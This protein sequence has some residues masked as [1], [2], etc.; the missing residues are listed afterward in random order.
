MLLPL[1]GDASL[2]FE[3]DMKRSTLFSLFF[4]FIIVALLWLK[5][6]GSFKKPADVTSASKKAKPEKIVEIVVPTNKPVAK[7]D[8]PK[9]AS[10]KAVLTNSVSEL[11]YLTDELILRVSDGST[12]KR[13][14]AALEKHGINIIRRVDEL[15]LV[16][17]KLPDGM[18]IPE[19]KKMLDELNEVSETIRNIRTEVPKTV[20]EL[21]MLGPERPLVPVQKNGLEIVQC[22]DP[23]NQATFGRSVTVALLDTGVDD[24]HPDLVDR[25]INGYNF[26][27]DTALTSDSHSHG[28]ACAGII[29]G[30]GLSEESVRGLAPAAYLL[31]VKVMNKNGKGESFAVVEGIV[32]AVDR[33][34]KVINL[35]IGTQGSSKILREAIDYANEH[36]AIVVAS[37]GNDGKEAVLFPAN[38]KDVIC[39]GAVDGNLNHAPFSNFGDA[40][41]IV[42]PGVGVY[43]TA[44]DGSYMNF[45]GTSSSAP[46]VSGALA[47]LISENPHDSPDEIYQKLLDSADNLGDAGRDSRFGEGILN[48]ERALRKKTDSAHDLALTSLFFDTFDLSPG[49]PITIYFVVENQG[50]E[51]VRGAKL[52][53][54]IAGKKI[55]KSVGTLEPGICKAVSEKWAIPTEMPQA[56]IRIEGYIISDKTDA[57]PDDNGKALILKESDWI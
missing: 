47:A 51:T 42:A 44:P 39:V 31:P 20:D 19:A 50:T 24:R 15:G 37:A 33:G 46:F 9:Q 3:K 25:I 49:L 57:E 56:E 7:I 48:V 11:P 29:V 5:W 52:V 54:N 34:A 30:A 13:L 43:T 22:T 21:P 35:S 18:T 6:H 41:D 55:E 2:R 16:R 4:I 45:S 28:T 23:A 53:L 32:Y 17:V 38:Y 27:D 14:E 10:R 1:K 26:V 36:G 40:V 12:I 8:P